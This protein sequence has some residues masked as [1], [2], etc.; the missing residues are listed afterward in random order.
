MGFLSLVLHASL[1]QASFSSS[2]QQRQALERLTAFWVIQG[3][4]CVDALMKSSLRQS[5]GTSRRGG[6]L[7]GLPSAAKSTG[8]KNELRYYRGVGELT[9]SYRQYDPLSL[10]WLL[11]MH[12]IGL[13]DWE[14]KPR[15]FPCLS[16]GGQEYMLRA[17]T[18]LLA[19]GSGG[20]TSLGKSSVKE[21]PPVSTLTP[22][23]T[24]SAMS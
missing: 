20:P 10:S 1:S 24:R 15:V 11:Y 18:C 12:R 2:L 21:R 16:F 23:F 5:L 13:L 19:A 14:R 7:S 4:G 3:G 8:Q 22:R 17:T 6:L 9:L